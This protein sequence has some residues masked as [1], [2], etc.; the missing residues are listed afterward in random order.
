MQ[1]DATGWAWPWWTVMVLIN[2]LNL[3]VCA[4]VFMR[5]R[6]SAGDPDARYR[7]RMRVMGVIFTLVAAYRSVFVCMYYSRMGWFDS[8]A[9]GPLLIRL[10]ALFAEVS[11]AGQF[12]LSMIRVNRDLAMSPAE[13]G[14]TL[15]R[16]FIQRA[17]YCLWTCICLAQIC[18]TTGV[19]TRSLFA[20]AVEETLWS[21]GFLSVLPLAFMQWRRASAVQDRSGRFALV[22]I[23][24]RV[25]LLWCAVYCTYGV[26]FA[27]PL[28]IWPSA[29]AQMRTGLP[30]LE[31]GLSAVKGAFKV[32]HA[33]QAWGDWGFGFLFWHSSYFS[34]C[35]WI[36]IFM[37]NA[38][39]RLR[40]GSPPTYAP[41]R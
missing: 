27:L 3:I 5:T 12:A 1:P 38:P 15:S 24:T 14:S 25:N 10:L 17:P 40:D 31:L 26:I 35:V 6:A 22:R 4:R 32:L 2:A 8:L 18:A 30:P 37:M 11:F 36:S 21:I 39:R 41:A 20:L 29:V 34:I 28:S 23:F 9:N 33:S 7:G 19:I 16:F 13:G